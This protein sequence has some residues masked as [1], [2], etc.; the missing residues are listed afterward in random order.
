MAM[1][2][3]RCMVLTVLGGLG[4]LGTMAL[5]V[6]CH[7]FSAP[8]Y[9][10]PKSDH[11]DGE[12][13]HNQDPRQAQ[14]SFWDWQLNRQ[15][16]PWR[17]W[18]DTPAGPPP[19][20]RVPKGA[21]RVTF[22]NHATTL[23]Q[24]DGL[25]VLTDPIWS[26]R[27][28]PVSFAGPHRVR[29]PGV[30]FEDLPPIDA[31]ILS[32]NHYDHMDVPTLKRLAA[33]FPNV[34]FF[35]GL[36]NRAFLESK[37]LRNTVELDWWQEVPLSPEVKLVST[38]AHHFSNRGL[39][40]GNGTLWTSYVLQGPSGVTYFAG[41]TGYGKHFRQV[42]E[43]FGPPRLAVLPIGAFRPEAFMEVV[44]VSPE[45]AV[46]AHLDLEAQVS[47][48]MHFGTFRLADD[49]QEEPVTRLH[50]AVEAQPGP[51]PAFWVLG[52]GEGRDIP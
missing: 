48:P 51:K 12:Q 41:D 34:R 29:P 50:A 30:R 44:H 18:T 52:F 21:L 11:F 3:R 8:V 26:D 42:R 2:R 19:P 33:Q 25:N 31:V 37:G 17:D 22:I 20:R 27:C 10:G 38:P 15:Q 16:G 7:A 39:S 23:L 49:G 24:L 40:D 46:Q 35:A 14:M 28:S 1:T 47:V 36:G 43:R 32:H 4:L 13:F 6:G 45:Q 5:G 9:Q